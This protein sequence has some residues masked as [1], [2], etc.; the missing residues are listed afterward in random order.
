[1]PGPLTSIYCSFHFQI[2]DFL[3][4]SAFVRPK[5]LPRITLT[6]IWE[7]A[8]KESCGGNVWEMIKASV[9]ILFQKSTLL[10]K[11]LLLFLK[12]IINFKRYKPTSQI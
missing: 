8:T 2:S 11:P 6:N 3:V 9:G 7:P 5:F 1:M 10:V 12:K 4:L